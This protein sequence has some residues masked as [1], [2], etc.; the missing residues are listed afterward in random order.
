MEGVIVIIEG[1][2]RFKEGVMVIIEGVVKLD[3]GVGS[4]EGDV[5][6]IVIRVGVVGVV[7]FDWFL[8]MEIGVGRF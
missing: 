1:V 7:V 3:E 8:D 6:V 2:G 5:I 4:C